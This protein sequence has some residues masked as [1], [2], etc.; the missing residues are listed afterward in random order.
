MYIYIYIYTYT[1]TYTCPRPSAPGAARSRPAASD[2]LN[3]IISQ[4]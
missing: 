2:Y 3:G 1:Y 4:D